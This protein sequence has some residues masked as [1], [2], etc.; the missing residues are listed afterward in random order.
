MDWNYRSLGISPKWRKQWLRKF[1]IVCACGESNKIC[2][3]LIAKK[4]RIEVSES[5]KV[6]EDATTMFTETVK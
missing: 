6:E 4:A 5:L 3:F 1:C 2:E